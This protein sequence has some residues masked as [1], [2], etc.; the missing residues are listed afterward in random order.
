MPPENAA[1]SVLAYTSALP[2]RVR[3][4]IQDISHPCDDAFDKLHS[5]HKAGVPVALSLRG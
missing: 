4:S 1:I 5:S 3:M 2:M